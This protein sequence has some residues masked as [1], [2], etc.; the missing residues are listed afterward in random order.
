MKVYLIKKEKYKKYESPDVAKR[1]LGK[2]LVYNDDG[3]PLGCSISHTKN[4]WVYA[5][6]DCGIDIEEKGRTV[7]ENVIR[8]LHPLEQKYMKALAYG[9][10]EWT[11]EFLHIWT[12]K[13]AWLKL[14]KTGLS[15]GL[16]SFSVLNEDL[17][18]RDEINGYRVYTLKH[19]NL[20]GALITDDE[21]E[22]IETIKYAGKHAKPCMDYAADL[23]AIKAYSR[24]DLCGKL[25]LK[26]YSEEEI[27]S[28]ADR[29]E[30]LGYLN[31]SEY[32]RRFAESAL[33]SNKG[34]G[35]VKQKLSKSGIAKED[36]PEFDRE[37]EYERAL[38]LGRS[39]YRETEDR[40]AKEKL[41]AKIGRKLASSGFEP[42]TV[43]KV[44]AK[45]R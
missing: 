5:E 36:M 37:E 45:L 8:R 41:L 3:A 2:E 19:R 15:G 18:Y 9:T 16:D 1:A 21:Y 20:T 22:G 25:K 10:S 17:S 28:C 6:G 11:E 29:L 43:Y 44:L 32:A 34:S 35:Y 23:L 13:E 42:S 38:A 4:Y 39:L 30:S 27:I 7:K 33:L 14:L 24:S 12:V 26:G 40:E 31:D